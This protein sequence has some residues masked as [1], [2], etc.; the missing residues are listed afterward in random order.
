MRPTE[1]DRERLRAALSLAARVHGDHKRPSGEPYLD[2]AR[3][4]AAGLNELGVDDTDTIVAAL[5]HDAL[6]P[7]TGLTEAML[8]AEF[9][10]TVAGL[11]RSA[12]SLDNYAQ[13]ASQNKT[14]GELGLEAQQDRQT[15]EAIRRALLSIIEGDIRIILIRMVDCLQDLRRAGTP[16]RDGQRR[17]AWEAL[18]IY[19]PIANRLG[20][21]HLK[22]QLEDNAFRYL[23]PEKYREIALRLDDG[24]DRRALKVDKAAARLRRRLSNLGVKAVVT[25]RPKHMYSIYRKMAR[26]ELDFEQIYDIQALRVIL[27]PQDKVAYR[28]L[29]SKAKDDADRDLCY[30]VLGAVH[31]L[32]Q[33]IRGE[34]D[35]YIGSPK[36]N[37]YMSL[38]T[39][40]IDETGQKLEV[41]IR[42]QRMH[43]E[44]EHGIAAHW[45][46]KEQGAKVSSS[47]QKRIQNLRELLA[48]LR[49]VE[50]DFDGAPPLDLARLEERIHVF[51]PK[52]DVLDMP[53]G[54]TPIDFAYQIH[55]EVGHRCRGARVNGKMV[56]LDY[57]LKS[58]DKVEI[59]TA[60]R[61]GPNRD[62]MNPSLGYTGSARTRSKIRHWFRQQ[63]REQNIQQGREV[64]ERE[65]RRLNLSDDIS[66]DD[67]ATVMKYDDVED[68]LCLVGFGDIQPNQIIGAIAARGQKRPETQDLQALL[69]NNPQTKSLTVHGVGG[70]HTRLA[71]CC[72]PVAPEPIIGYVT[73]GQGIT[74]HT[75]SCP[76]V[77]A[78][79]ERE[80]LID[81]E[82]G[83]TQQ[84][85]PVP[86]I[87]KSLPRSGLIEDLVN[88]LRGQQINVPKTKLINEQDLTTVY[89]IAEVADLT[90][91]NNLLTKLGNLPGV[92]EVRRQ[93]WS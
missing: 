13:R 42:T 4:V 26:K 6:L 80:R 35:D 88:L 56:S 90:Q 54:A 70:V 74:I 75:Q 79:T 68:F 25:G 38:H 45:A 91:L 27:E 7:H 59:I 9:G 33:P 89:L 36:P 84:S 72:T 44:A 51:T 83:T 55:T 86:V 22:W 46:Y 2:H 23:E 60:K 73:R 69:R 50:D 5:L 52:D 67:I 65:L 3:A 58:G 57:R 32:W 28:A 34:F 76:Q 47:S 93:T 29:S 16:D 20:I 40:V 43:E 18:H 71:Q 53:A 41:Q 21:W 62:W 31:S 8:T 39:A 15:L 14:A 64:V 77:A 87:L 92:Q 1:T 66:V 81:V 82:W 11:V 30:Q 48:T 19:A 85:H 61:G 12:R 78:I 63:D 37:G 24:R 17:L 10:P 49:E